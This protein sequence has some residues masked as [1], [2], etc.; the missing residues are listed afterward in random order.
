MT[1][2][3]KRKLELNEFINDSS[4]VNDSFLKYDNDKFIE[5]ASSLAYYL[6]LFSSL[7][8]FLESE[9]ASRKEADLRGAINN[10]QNSTQDQKQK[11]SMNNKTDDSLDDYQLSRAFDLILALDLAN[12]KYK[13]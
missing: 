5:I 7:K 1:F 8:K 9:T 12:N 11:K 6:K 13:L 3:K 2:N 10:E 4:D